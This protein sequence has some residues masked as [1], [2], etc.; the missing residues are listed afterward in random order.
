[1][2]ATLKIII[3]SLLILNSIIGGCIYLTQGVTPYASLIGILFAAA[4]ISILNRQGR[5]EED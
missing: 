1:V 3:V 5:N 2:L 4:G